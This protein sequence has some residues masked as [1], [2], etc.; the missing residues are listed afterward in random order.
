MLPFFYVAQF[1]ILYYICGMDTK[2]TTPTPESVAADFV[3]Y[4]TSGSGLNE[5]EISVTIRMVISE[6]NNR[7]NCRIEELE[8]Q[9]KS[10]MAAIAELDIP[11]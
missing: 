1:S 2:A 7:R 8:A 6:I 9:V 11:G 3:N 4:L 10:I 5:H